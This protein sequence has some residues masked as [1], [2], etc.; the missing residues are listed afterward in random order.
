MR[1]ILELKKTLKF[2]LCNFIFYVKILMAFQKIF[3]NMDLFLLVLKLSEEIN[4]K[5]LEA[6][7]RKDD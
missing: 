1:K 4:K 7:Q 2:F 5:Y 6:K 3:T